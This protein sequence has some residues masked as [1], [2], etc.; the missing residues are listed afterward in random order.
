MD[1][2]CLVGPMGRGE[3]SLGRE[4]VAA[5]GYLWYVVYF[6]GRYGRFLYSRRPCSAVTDWVGNIRRGGGVWE[7]NVIQNTF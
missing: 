2:C 1:G 3:D 5:G 6:S 7:L 4:G